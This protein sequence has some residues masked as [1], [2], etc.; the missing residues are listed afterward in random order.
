M[1][2]ARWQVLP[3]GHGPSSTACCWT[4]R[5]MALALAVLAVLASGFCAGHWTHGKNEGW[6]GFQWDFRGK[7]GAFDRIWLWKLMAVDHSERKSQPRKSNQLWYIIDWVSC[8][9][10][11]VLW[12]SLYVHILVYFGGEGPQ[13]LIH[14]WLS[15]AEQWTARVFERN[16]AAT[17]SAARPS[18]INFSRPKPFKMGIWP[19]KHGKNYRLVASKCFKHVNKTSDLRSMILNFVTLVGHWNHPEDLETWTDHCPGPLVDFS[20][21]YP[22][23]LS[24]ESGSCFPEVKVM[25]MELWL[26][27]FKGV[28]REIFGHV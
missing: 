11:V 28:E 20:K 6:R 9:K 25:I 15:D 8:F 18:N 2:H 14:T 7:I 22:E 27:L 19:S 26:N 1:P 3:R 12:C 10:H 4:P 17:L 5:P 21:E 24:E 13:R 23:R 16:F